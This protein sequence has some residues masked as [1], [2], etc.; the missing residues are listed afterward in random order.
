MYDRPV[1]ISKAKIVR[2]T[3][4]VLRAITEPA[5][6]EVREAYRYREAK[7]IVGPHRNSVPPP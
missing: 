2:C 5:I 6:V 3:D 7:A 4:G 1:T